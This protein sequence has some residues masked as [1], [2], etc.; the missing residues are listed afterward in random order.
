MRPAVRE[1]AA[2]ARRRLAEA[3]YRS[4]GARSAVIDALAATGGCCGAQE[5]CD[6]LRSSGRSAGTASVYRAL[7]VLGD[8]GLVR[9]RDV[10]EGLARYE[11]VLPSGEHHHH[12]VCDRCGATEPF[13]DPELEQAIHRA[14]ERATFR[15]QD[16][17]VVLHGLCPDCAEQG[18]RPRAAPE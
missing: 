7:G 12:V 18:D 2:E 1:W 10:G 17:D 5:L 16:H 4:G 3:G 9:G 8:L 14:G 6:H 11:L 13:E 15:V